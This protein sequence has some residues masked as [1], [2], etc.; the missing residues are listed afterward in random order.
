MIRAARSQRVCSERVRPLVPD[1]RRRKSRPETLRQQQRQTF[2]AAFEA[3]RNGE[4]W[5][6]VAPI[7][8]KPST[9]GVRR[10]GA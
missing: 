10:R 2:S 1:R 5:R 9:E 7:F 3:R 8:R 4:F 6:A